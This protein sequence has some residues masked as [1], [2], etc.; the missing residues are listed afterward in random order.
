MGELRFQVV[1]LL[2]YF[3]VGSPWLACP[4][5]EEPLESQHRGRS[6]L[7]GCPSFMCQ[8]ELKAKDEQVHGEKRVNEPREKQALREA[9]G[10][11][12]TSK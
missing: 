10:K 8:D 6:A 9:E 1:P 5:G 2:G 4:G 3:G 7:A 12:R 11:L